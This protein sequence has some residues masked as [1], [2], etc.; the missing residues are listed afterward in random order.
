MNEN[1]LIGVRIFEKVVGHTLPRSGEDDLTVI[2]DEHGFA[3]L[4]IVV[5]GLNLEPFEASWFELLVVNDFRGNRNGFSYLNYLGRWIT[6]VQ[7]GVHAAETFSGKQL[8]M[9]QRAVRFS[10][11]RVALGWYLTE[12]VVMHSQGVLSESLFTGQDGLVFLR[13][14]KQLD[15]SLDF[16]IVP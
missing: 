7:Q 9:I 15:G 4:E 16:E 14:L 12:A 5:F 1:D 13:I 2:V 3:A 11:L 10:K 6:M 8:F